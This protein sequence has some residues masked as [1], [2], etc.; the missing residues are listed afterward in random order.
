MDC[1]GCK[2][3]D[4]RVTDTRFTGS[5]IVKRRRECMR[6]GLR[7]VTEEQIKNLTKKKD[8]HVLIT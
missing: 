3:P 5:E 7:I 6:C 4:L 2:Y 8:K 1:P